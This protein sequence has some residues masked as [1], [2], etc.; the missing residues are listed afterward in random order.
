MNFLLTKLRNKLLAI[1]TISMIVVIIPI[2]FGFLSAYN[3][4]T[5]VD[6]VFEQ[7]ISQERLAIG[8][9]LNFKKQVQEWK[10]VLIR[11]KDPKQLEK[12]WD[13][14]QKTEAKI[15]ESG[16]ILVTQLENQ[17]AK[18]LVSQ[19]IEE[20]KKMGVAYRKG[21]EAFK[22][23]NFDPNAGDKAVKGID[24]A[25]T[26]ML[27][28]AATFIKKRSTENFHS[29]VTEG[30]GG[31]FNTLY[32][33]LPIF[34]VIAA[35]FV[36]FMNIAVGRPAS[37]VK[38][39]LEGLAAGDFT[40][41]LEC[42]SKDEFGSIAVSAQMVQTELGNLIQT[43]SRM[44]EKLDSDSSQLAEFSHQN[45]QVIDNQNQQSER[46]SVSM[47]E[48]TTTIQDVARHATEAA[49]QAT[50]A[51]SQA[52]DGNSLV[53]QVLTSINNLAQEVGN[54]ATAVNSVEQGATEIGSVIDVINGIAEQ[55]NLL[56]LNAAIEAARAGEQ[57]R[58]FAVVADE[59]R[60]LAARTQESTEEIRAMIEKLQKG[61]KSAAHAMSLGEEKVA[62]TE[63]LAAKADTALSKITESVSSISLANM[64]IASAAEEQGSVS[65][66][67][68]ENVA[69]IRNLANEVYGIVQQTDTSTTDLAELSSELRDLTTKFKI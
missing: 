10:D 43:I 44:A 6:S 41:H 37:K 28:E 20:H 57:G 50:D 53:N 29:S 5:K 1:V 30:Q 12:Y 67:I 48:M 65:T 45:M 69:S 25:P 39:Y 52:R 59:V 26:K 62:E 36:V 16:E 18:T 22:A 21:F 8:M 68:N 35:A 47:N 66:E 40:Q 64:Q 4:L 15:Q 42:T 23:A 38:V 3:S 24:R 2:F 27:E 9:A 61:T 32:I 33:L 51:D 49:A 17:E 63:D 56:A 31:I 54:T 7:K 46:V 13:K 14:F 19:F 55:T 11:G 60:T 58:G 34:V